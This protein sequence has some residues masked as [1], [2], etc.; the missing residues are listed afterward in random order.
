V[1][2]HLLTPPALVTVREP[3][4]TRP[5]LL[6]ATRGERCY[7]QVSRGLGANHLVW[8]GSGQVVGGPRR[9]R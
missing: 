9:L 5:A 2:L 3:G 8:V 7:L 1:R 6:L 4:G